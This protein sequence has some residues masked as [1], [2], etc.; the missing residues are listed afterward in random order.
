MF[1]HS[2][3]LNGVQNGLVQSRTK[4]FGYGDLIY[5]MGSKQLI[6]TSSSK[7]Q[8]CHLSPDPHAACI[9]VFS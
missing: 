5:G 2:F 9:R 7:F 4:S 1:V 8:T 3:A 6:V